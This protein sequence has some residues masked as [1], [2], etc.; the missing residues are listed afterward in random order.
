MP[1][2]KLSVG[3]MSG[4]H[5]GDPRAMTTMVPFYNSTASRRFRRRR[6]REIGDVLTG[7]TL[8]KS[9]IARQFGELVDQ[10]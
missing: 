5:P 6:R 9:S 8:P 7:P 1:D 4:H 10:Y 3:A 2:R